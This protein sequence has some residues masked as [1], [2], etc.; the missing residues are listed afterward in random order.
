M[1]NKKGQ[2]EMVGFVLIVVLVIV[3]IM[4]FLVISIK[5]GRKDV[6]SK[7]VENLLASVMS[8]TTECA[9]VSEPRY[10]SVED[11]IKSCF[12][13]DKCSNLEKMACNYLEE[14]MEEIMGDIIRSEGAVSGYKFNIISKINDEENPFFNLESGNMTGVILGGQRVVVSEGIELIAR[15]SLSYD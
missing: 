2:S 9:I 4:V 1:L 12:D 15:L 11:L 6:E 7:D 8:Y 3:A 10:D 5:S 14:L 13:N